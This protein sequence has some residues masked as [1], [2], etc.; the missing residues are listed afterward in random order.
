MVWLLP[1][2]TMAAGAA[3]GAYSTYTR[4]EQEQAA[5]KQQK[6]AA[7]Q[8]YTH[9]KAHSDKQF[10]ISKQNALETLAIERKNLD[11]QVDM[12]MDDYNTA[13]LSQAYG[14]QDARIQTGSAAGMNLAAEGASGTRGNSS[15]EAVRAYAQQGL[16]RNINIQDQQND[17]YLNRMIT[18]ANTTLGAIFREEDSWMPG[19]HRIKSKEAQDNYNLN[20]AN[21]G[22]SNFD[23]QLDQYNPTKNP[24]G[25]AADYMTGMFGGASSGFSMGVGY[26]DWLKQ[27]N[28]NAFFNAGKG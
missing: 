13:L 17:N 24:H 20:I 14:I 28:N 1:V 12:S 11:T 3:V 9:G 4:R 8:A 27:M 23:W 2:I 26:Q 22:Q 21:L 7:W 6:E 18:G 10:D 25:F 15:G 16:E 19:G 5:I